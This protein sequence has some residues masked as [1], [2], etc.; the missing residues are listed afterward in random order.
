M[1]CCV[2]DVLGHASLRFC[3]PNTS[4]CH[5]VPSGFGENRKPRNAKIFKPS[6]QA[7]LAEPRRLGERLKRPCR[8]SRATWTAGIS[9]PPLPVLFPC[10]F[11]SSTTCSKVAGSCRA[12]SH[13]PSAGFKCSVA[14]AATCAEHGCRTRR[15][16]R[17]LA[18]RR[19]CSCST[20]L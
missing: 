13:G 4:L 6:A 18:S 3:S 2:K 20:G 10:L 15:V 12:H 11:K 1:L 16:K 7:D 9:L 5:P 8:A 19:F 14:A 17:C